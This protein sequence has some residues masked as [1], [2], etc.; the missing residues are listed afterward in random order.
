MILNFWN[1]LRMSWKS[2]LGKSLNIQMFYKMFRKYSEGLLSQ[3]VQRKHFSIHCVIAINFSY[4]ENS[5]LFQS[6]KYIDNSPI[7]KI[8]ELTGIK[9]TITEIWLSNF[10]T[11]CHYFFLQIWG[12][13]SEQCGCLHISLEFPKS[14]LEGLPR[15]VGLIMKF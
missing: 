1:L 14:S 9:E 6:L 4:S 11:K 2:S 3:W 15:T 12:G 5:A 7:K 10:I 13:A 8:P